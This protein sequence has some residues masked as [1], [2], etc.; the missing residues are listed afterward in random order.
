MGKVLLH[1]AVSLDGYI[2][3]PDGADVG[4]YDWYAVTSGS[5]AIPRRGGRVAAQ[6]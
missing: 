3:G 6:G 4:L 1:L 5:P 2:D